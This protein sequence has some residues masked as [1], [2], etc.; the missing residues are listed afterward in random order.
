MLHAL[1]LTLSLSSQ[2]AGPIDITEQELTQYVNQKAKY[3]QQYG[4]P[5]LFD[6]D[7]NIES[8]QV[9]LG[10]QKANMAQVLSNGQF[11]L[12]MPGQTPIDGT[13]S[14]I[15]E[16][17]PRYQLKNGAVYLDNFTLTSYQIKPAEVQ[18]QFAP[19][20]GYLVQGLQSRLQQQPAYVLNSKDKDQ[21]WL[22]K[23]VTRF[24]L[25]PGKLRLY[26]AKS[27]SAE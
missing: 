23:H 2:T 13:I 12:T 27:G 24:E 3:Q 16:A 14:A 11:T 15:F 20:V 1:L 8:M 6:V 10:R 18:Q 9:R 25:L 7:V 21:L 19:L 22:K 26:T 4:L 17:K 5:G